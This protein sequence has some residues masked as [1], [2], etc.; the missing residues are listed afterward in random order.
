MY[1]DAQYTSQF[2]TDF[3]AIHTVGGSTHG[4]TLLF[5]ETVGPIEPQIWVKMY[6]R[7]QFFGFKLDGR[8]FFEEKT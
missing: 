6:P 2:W 8:R 3:R 1:N 4:W 7:N 5:L